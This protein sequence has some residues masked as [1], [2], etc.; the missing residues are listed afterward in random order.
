MQLKSNGGPKPDDGGSLKTPLST[1]EIAEMYLSGQIDI[2]PDD[3]HDLPAE[4]L[5]HVKTNPNEYL[6]NY[7]RELPGELDFDA[8]N[9]GLGK[10][11]M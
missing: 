4:Y 2:Q 10:H 8:M 6:A 9:F 7:L 3:F 5:H 11:G 1:A